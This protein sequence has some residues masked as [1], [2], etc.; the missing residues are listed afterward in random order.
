MRTAAA[1]ATSRSQ[2]PYS[3]PIIQN[4]LNSEN[5]QISSI[6][7]SEAGQCWM[8]IGW[9]NFHILWDFRRS[10]VYLWFVWIDLG[11]LNEW[12]MENND[13]DDDEKEKFPSFISSKSF[14]A[15]F[16][17]SSRDVLN[18]ISSSQSEVKW[19]MR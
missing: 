18:T 16:L 3:S 8:N 13:W 4:Y 14:A 7:G 11:A 17:T 12:W 2:I 5:D 15:L 19:K 9:V 6:D 10:S 1:V